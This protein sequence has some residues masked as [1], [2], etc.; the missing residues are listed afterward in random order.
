MRKTLIATALAFGLT[1]PAMASGFFVEAALGQS[2]VDIPSEPGVTIDDSDTY[3]AISGGYAINDMF[4]VEVG[5]ANLGE[6]SASALG[7]IAT[8]DVDGYTL[9]LA[10]SLPV[11]E[12]FSVTGR[13]GTYFWDAN[14]TLNGESLGSDDG[15]DLYYGIAGYYKLNDQIKVGAGWNRYTFD[16]DGDDT[17]VDT[18]SVNVRFSF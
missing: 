9:G 5:H 4:A 12:K 18:Y 2:N 11:G 6:A 8:V 16:S 13:L 1:S 14:A 15:N 3:Y 10:L 7:N 17:D